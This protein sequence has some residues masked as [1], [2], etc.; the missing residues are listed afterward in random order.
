MIF[1]YKTIPSQLP[2]VLSVPSIIIGRVGV[3]SA[4]KTFLLSR[5]IY[6]PLFGF[7]FMCVPSLIKKVIS[8]VLQLI[9]FGK[10][11]GHVCPIIE[12]LLVRLDVS[13]KIPL[14][15]VMMLFLPKLEIVFML[16]K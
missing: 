16:L 9:S 3:P 14:D 11:K 7:I 1:L 15:V 5:A 2:A 6:M 10:M 4:L 13:T 8:A 12:T